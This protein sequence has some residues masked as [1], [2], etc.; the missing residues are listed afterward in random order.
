MDVLKEIRRNVGKAG[1][2]GCKDR[3]FQKT[4]K[5]SITATTIKQTDIL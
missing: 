3:A 1:P 2:N 4:I 5:L